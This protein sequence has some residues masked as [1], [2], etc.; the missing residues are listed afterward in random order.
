[1]CLS[2]ER[3]SCVYGGEY[4]NLLTVACSAQ[5]ASQGHLFKI[6]NKENF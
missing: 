2:G 6:Y 3:E 4:A 1:M 5:N